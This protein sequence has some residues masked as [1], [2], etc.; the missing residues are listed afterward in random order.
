[1][2]SLPADVATLHP[3]RDVGA[4]VIGASAGAFDALRRI[5]PSL[6]CRSFPT[7]VVVHQ[8]PQGSSNLAELFTGIAALP[9]AAIEDKDPAHHGTVYFAPAGYHLLVER[10]ESFAL[11]TEAP[12]N[13]SRPSIDVLFESA[14]EVWGARLAAL[15]LTGANDDG[16]R[17]LRCIGEA[18]GITLVQDP[19]D[20]EVGM[21][22]A[23]A[24]ALARPRATLTLERLAALFAAW[25]QTERNRS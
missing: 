25:S 17:G 10:D 8:P 7:I 23:A 13:F 5:L 11:S 21:M 16:A 3:G 1:V 9:C 18:G 19:A 14:A 22:P 20:A 4:L 15:V 6:D 12:V 2:S 24:I